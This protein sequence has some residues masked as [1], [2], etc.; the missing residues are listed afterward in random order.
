MRTALTLSRTAV[1]SLL[2]LA[3]AS[4]PTLGQISIGQIQLWQNQE[5]TNETGQTVYDLRKVFSGERTPS[6][7]NSDCF[8]DWSFVAYDGETEVH[9]TDGTVTDGT[10]CSACVYW[11]EDSSLGVKYA[12]WTDDSSNDAADAG[13]PFGGGFNFEWGTGWTDVEVAFQNDWDPVFEDP[14]TIYATNVMWTTVSEPYPLSDLTS[15]LFS[16]LVWTDLPDLHLDT[17][18]STTVNLGRGFAEDTYVIVAFQTALEDS[19]QAVTEIWQTSVNVYQGVVRPG[20]G[21]ED[22]EDVL[23]LY[24]TGDPPMFAVPVTSPEPVYEGDY[25]LR[26]ED[27]SESGTPQ[28]YVA[29]ITG[30]LDGDEVTAQFH[31]YDDTPGSS[32]SCRIWG[33]WN[34][35]D[36]VMGYNGSAGGNSDYGPGTGWDLADYTWTV[37]DGHTGLVVEV[38]TYSNP[39]D[40]VWI[41]ELYVVAPEHAAVVT[42]CYGLVPVQ[43]KSWGAIKALYR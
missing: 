20:C 15:D 9:F 35:S 16:T 31:R 17:D 19:S 24:G 1:L 23:G 27:N 4:A 41:D 14:A 11:S 3:A 13:A 36:D 30:L 18:A 12:V 5:Y 33:H 26:L 22:G 6:S 21:W 8:S 40:T 34:D 2:I 25:S 38:R 43:D 32:P 7:T 28:A 42:P 10:T 39:G 37:V 29:W